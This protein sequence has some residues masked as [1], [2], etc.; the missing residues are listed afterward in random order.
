MKI[1]IA[2]D[3]SDFS[4][5]AIER[6]CEIIGDLK[7]VSVEIIS[8][9]DKPYAPPE[10]FAVSADYNRD[11]EAEMR[12]Q[13]KNFTDQAEAQFRKRLPDSDLEITTK[14]FVGKPERAII[15]E[16]E[17]CGTDLIVLG[18]HGYGFWKRAWLGSV[19]NSVMQHAPCSVLI[20]RRKN[21]IQS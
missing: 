7:N 8:V 5:A 14:I 17:T 1:L 11:V 4:K 6:A 21:S 18:S 15:E 3:G 13:A 10:P 16:A 12:K 19:S 9:V 20:V 2:T